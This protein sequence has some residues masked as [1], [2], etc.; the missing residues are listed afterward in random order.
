LLEWLKYE[1]PLAIRN[2]PVILCSNKAQAAQ[3]QLGMHLGAKLFME[4]PLQWNQII[5][6]L[7]QKQDCAL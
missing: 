1:A 4:K 2:I 7:E 6:L 5:T 3:I